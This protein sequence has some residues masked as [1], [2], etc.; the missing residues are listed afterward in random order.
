MEVIEFLKENTLEDLTIQFGIKVKEYPEHG[1][2]V[3]NYDQID[4]P[5]YH[6]IVKECRGLIIDLNVL[7]VVSK[8]FSRFYNL[9]ENENDE[10]NFDEPFRAEEKADGSLISVYWFNNS[11]C[12]ASRGNAFAEGTTASGLSFKEIFETA[13]GTD[14]N[15]FMV[16]M[17]RNQSYTFELCSV[18]NKVV[19]LYNE[20]VVYLLNATELPSYETGDSQTLDYLA[21]DL[22]VKRPEVYDINSVEE[23]HESFKDI[24]PTDEGYVLIDVNGN[25][26]KVKNPTYVD[27]H[28]LKGNGEIT[29]KRITDVV[30]RG[31]TE[32]VLGYFPEYREFFEPWQEAYNTL[33]NNIDDNIELVYNNT[34][35]QKEFAL[36]IKDLH[37]K[38]VL[39][40]MRKGL[41][42]QE[43][44]DKIGSTGKVSLL[45][46]WVN[47]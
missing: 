21:E 38:G 27:L 39:F 6:P 2:A 43:A 7:V 11:W 31:E 32:E 28:H 22:G 46:Y 20:P 13:I 9:N 29:P 41:T 25:R 45:E 42:I 18:Y 44:F 5:K 19:K 24:E 37:F 8:T 4:S 10:F 23:I 47:N 34:Y 26:I 30:F 14:V 40:S 35:S 12:V 33:I 36:K 16:D 17:F 1:I 3:L 15:S